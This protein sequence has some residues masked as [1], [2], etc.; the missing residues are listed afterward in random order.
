MFKN[1]WN[2]IFQIKKVMKNSN[3][4]NF[5]QQVYPLGQNQV[6]KIFLKKIVIKI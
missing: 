5:K 6:K 3:K 2:K 4:I 1:I